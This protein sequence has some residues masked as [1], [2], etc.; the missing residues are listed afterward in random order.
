MMDKEF[1]KNRYR[2]FSTQEAIPVFSQPWW[3]D[4][5]CGENN[6][7]VILYEKGGQIVASFPYYLK[8]AKV[9]ELCIPRLTQKMGPYIKYPPKQQRLEKRLAYEREVMDYIIESLPD[10]DI[11]RVNFDYTVT[12]WLPFYWKGFEQSTR[13]TYIV[14]DLSDTVQVFESF[15]SGKKTDIKKASKSVAVKYD[16]GGGNFIDYYIDCLASQG[17]TLAYSRDFFLRLYDAAIENQQGRIIYAVDKDNPN[18]IFG[19][20]F[21]IWD[22][23]AIY[24][25]VTAFHPLYRST[26]APSLL[27]WQIMKDFKDSGLK[28]DFEGSMIEECEKSYNKFGCLQIPYFC[29]SHHRTKKAKIFELLKVVKNE[30]ISISSK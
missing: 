13:Y 27:F 6:W 11:F 9:K 5:V 16:L 24:S 29:I 23:T 25:L 1:R 26:G 22:K 20:I 30:I 15:A 19:A 10:Y 2:Q 14:P 4:A 17:K 18:K 3:L 12:N 21:Y 8:T 28:F 7:D